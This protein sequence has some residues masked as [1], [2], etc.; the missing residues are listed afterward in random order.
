MT[1]SEVLALCEGNSVAACVASYCASS[2]SCEGC[3]S[4][5]RGGRTWAT[6]TV[7]I[8]LNSMSRLK[9]MAKMMQPIIVEIFIAARLHA[10][11]DCQCEVH[12]QAG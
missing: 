7:L 9:P 12:G 10:V 8:K 11:R 4:T 5:E 3:L 2:W 1:L 6:R